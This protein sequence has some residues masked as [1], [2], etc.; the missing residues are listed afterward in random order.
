M[1]YTPTEV[2][3]IFNQMDIGGILLSDFIAKF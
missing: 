3:K 1:H 2:A